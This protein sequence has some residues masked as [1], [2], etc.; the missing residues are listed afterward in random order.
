[1]NEWREGVTEWI[2]VLSNEITQYEE[3]EEEVEIPELNVCDHDLNVME[4]E[5]HQKRVKSREKM[6]SKQW[7]K[8][9]YRNWNGRGDDMRSLKRMERK[10]RKYGRILKY[11]LCS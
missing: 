11:V 4:D 7:K 1:M 2:P 6:Q 10:R 5:R 8:V 3:E 9:K